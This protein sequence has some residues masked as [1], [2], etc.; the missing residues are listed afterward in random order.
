MSKGSGRRPG[1]MPPENWARIFENVPLVCTACK[2][3]PCD[4]QRTDDGPEQDGEEDH[5][6]VSDRG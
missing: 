2:N 3:E 4:C 1:V 6:H 5:G